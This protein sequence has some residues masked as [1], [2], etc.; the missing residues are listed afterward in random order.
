MIAGLS[1]AQKLI[2]GAGGLLL[3]ALALFAAAKAG[4]ARHW[5][6]VADA[7][8]A[9]LAAAG[10]ALDAQNKAVAGWKAEADARA[11]AAEAALKAARRHG[12]DLRALAQR[13]E[14]PRPLSGR[15]LTPSDVKE[16]KL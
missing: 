3:L 9:R 6:K 1:L 5:H 7:G 12:E 10:A 2:G 11:K 4:E 8:A 15:C 14:A 16:I 13:I